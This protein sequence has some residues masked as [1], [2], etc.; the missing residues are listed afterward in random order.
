MKRRSFLNAVLGMF[1]LST[2]RQAKA[3]DSYKPGWSKNLI[4]QEL[5]IDFRQWDFQDW[6][7]WLQREAQSYC[8]RELE[9]RR[10]PMQWSIAV[11][12]FSDEVCASIDV[13][14]ELMGLRKNEENGIVTW[15]YHPISCTTAREIWHQRLREAMEDLDR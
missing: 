1:G 15:G 7:D 14:H 6:M 2:L 9:V 8:G 3:V 5:D 11:C 12:Q 13:W 4:V 10:A